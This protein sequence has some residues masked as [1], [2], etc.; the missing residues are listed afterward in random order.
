MPNAPCVSII[1]SAYNRPHVVRFAIRSV[2]QSDFADWEMIVVGDGC[3]AETEAAI[4]S[5]DDPRIRFHNL[6]HNTGHQ[7]APHNKGVEMAR[8]EFVFFLNQDDLWFPD[9]LAARVA[10]MRETGADISWSPILLLNRSGLDEGPLDVDNDSVTLDGAI[11]TGEFDPRSF[12]ISSC[13]A[14]RREIC[15]AVGPWLPKDATRLSPSQEWLFRAHRQGRKMRYHPYVSVLCI[16]SG[17]RRYSYVNARSVDH[18]R[19]WTWVSG[20][21]TARLHMMDVLAVQQARELVEKRLELGKRKRP[22]FTW[23]QG[24]FEKAGVHPDSFRR[25]FSGIGKGGFVNTHT[26][27]TS[28]PPELKPGEVLPFGSTVANDLVGDGWHEAEPHGR[29]T[30]ARKADLFFS[31]PKRDGA[32]PAMAVEIR[33]RPLS[34]KT[35]IRFELDGGEAIER[36]MDNIDATVSIPVPGA[37]AH[38]L[39]IAVEKLQTPLQLGMSDDPRELGF[40]ITTLRLVEADG[41]AGYS[42]VD[43]ATTE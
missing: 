8:G 30:K 25:A 17:V 41:L 43:G 2:L 36:Q 9:H 34:P 31:S 26:R 7:S 4:R 21:D 29:W 28:K 6:P 35:R 42:E 23:M 32:R 19:A 5:F 11:A 33:G 22:L 39:L 12:I 40:W 3:N 37:G 27:F 13:W 24:L 18:E 20:G 14:V 15:Q 38:H 10:F 1:I 16:H